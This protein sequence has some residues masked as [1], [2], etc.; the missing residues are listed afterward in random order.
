MGLSSASIAGIVVGILFTV[1]I[2]LLIGG[3]FTKG[4][5]SSSKAPVNIIVRLQEQLRLQEQDQSLIF[6]ILMILQL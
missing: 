4:A 3:W 5:G 1:G 2:I 6:E